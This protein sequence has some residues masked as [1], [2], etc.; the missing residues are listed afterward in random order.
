MKLSPSD[1]VRFQ[2][3]AARTELANPTHDDVR[4]LVELL[5]E[6]LPTEQLPARLAHALGR[7]VPR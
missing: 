6:V 1:K 3:I 7:G 2:E 5:S 4:F